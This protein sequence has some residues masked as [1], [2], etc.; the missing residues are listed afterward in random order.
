MVRN[1]STKVIEK[2]QW[3]KRVAEG[4]T[5]VNWI[6]SKGM[7]HKYWISKISQRRT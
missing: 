1:G 6:Y 7:K 3:V 2:V 5:E 4:E